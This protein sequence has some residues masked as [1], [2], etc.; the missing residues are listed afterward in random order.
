[1]TTQ[2]EPDVTLRAKYE[3]S[4]L[5]TLEA[6]S[7]YIMREVAAQFERPVLLL[8]EGISMYLTEHDGLALLQHVVDRF[9]C[10][11]LQIDFYNWLAI[12]SQKTH[13]LQQQSGSTLYWAVNGP[14]DIVNRVS[15]LRLLTAA[16]FFDA[17][18]FSRVPTGFRRA[19][20]LVRAVPPLR[21]M[22]QYH[23]Y[24]FGPVN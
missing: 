21:R 16:T 24:A 17:S 9:R 23:R 18:T 14:K 13:R 10:G 6:E 5:Q 20:G 4:H 22:F 8:A 19:S 3:L 12:R 15:G 11:E 1:M 7:I 2:A